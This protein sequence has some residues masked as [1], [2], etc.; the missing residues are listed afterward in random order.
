MARA[1]Q[2]I[3]FAAVAS[4]DMGPSARQLRG[5]AANSTSLASASDCISF[6]CWWPAG[7]CSDCGTDW[8]NRMY[9][10]VATWSAQ[11]RT[12][13]LE[14]PT[15]TTTRNLIGTAVAPLGC[16]AVS[17][18]ASALDLRTIAGAPGMGTTTGAATT[19]ARS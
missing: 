5:Y 8:N 11:A 19:R 1:M 2:V 12:A 16:A 15:S 7:E 18:E 6:C 4:A 17:R 14:R 3:G 13:A 9:A 10:P